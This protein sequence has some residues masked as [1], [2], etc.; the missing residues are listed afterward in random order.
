MQ[1]L[2]VENQE[3]IIREYCRGKYARRG[4]LRSMI[5]RFF[6]SEDK[7]MELGIDSGEYKNLSSL[8]KSVLEAVKKSGYDIRT[9]TKEGHLY[10]IKGVY[11]NADN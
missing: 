8:Q 2:K 7:V 9:F 1:E 11:T 3:A 4:K 5:D 6:A 10:I